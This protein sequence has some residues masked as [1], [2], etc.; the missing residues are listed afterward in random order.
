MSSADDIK[1]V[2]GF[3][4][5]EVYTKYMET[6]KWMLWAQNLLPWR[7]REAGFP[8]FNSSCVGVGTGKPYSAVLII[9]R[10]SSLN[11]FLIIYTVL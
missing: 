5:N 9:R 8:T 2:K 6:T 10:N 7:I 3:S 4:A 11:D 1:I